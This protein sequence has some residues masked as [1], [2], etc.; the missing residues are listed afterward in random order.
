MLH[1]EVH[2]V[3]FRAPSIPSPPPS[4]F[5]LPLFSNNRMYLMI[6]AACC[7]LEHGWSCCIYPD[8]QRFWGTR[9]IKLTLLSLLHRYPGFYYGG[10][11]I[12]YGRSQWVND[13]LCVCTEPEM[14]LTHSG[15][16]TK[17]GK[18][19]SWQLEKTLNKV[20][21][22][23]NLS[24]FLSRYA[25]YSA[26]QPLRSDY[27]INCLVRWSTENLKAFSCHDAL[28]FTPLLS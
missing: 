16:R 13:G 10:V 11:L 20:C 6:A 5:F 21:L 26:W 25:I 2:P 9:R 18:K 19:T 22:G 23:P 28:V 17:G 27:R 7:A 24:H 1:Y 3:V 14:F 12:Q 4:S 15:T 8:V